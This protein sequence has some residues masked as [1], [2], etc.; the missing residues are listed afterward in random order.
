MWVIRFTV[1]KAE[2][3]GKT[4]VLVNPYNSHSGP[5]TKIANNYGVCV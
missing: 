2:R 3:A 5:P 1:R 4:V